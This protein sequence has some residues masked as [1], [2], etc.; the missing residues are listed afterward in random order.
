MRDKLALTHLK[1]GL[2]LPNYRA[3][4]I[5]GVANLATAMK[6]QRTEDAVDVSVLKKALDI[7]KSNAQTLIQSVTPASS[8]PAHL[9]QNVNVVA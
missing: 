2:R 4:D 6:Q 3:M 7:Q 5:S 9:G 8:L 1:F